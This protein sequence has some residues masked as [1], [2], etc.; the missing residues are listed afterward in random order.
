MVGGEQG[1]LKSDAPLAE[2]LDEGQMMHPSGRDGITARADEENIP[3][4]EIRGQCTK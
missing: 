2:R 1:V 3:V 4:G